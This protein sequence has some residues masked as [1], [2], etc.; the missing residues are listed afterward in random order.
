[1]KAIPRSICIWTLVG[2]VIPLIWLCESCRYLAFQYEQPW[3]MPLEFL[4]ILPVS[5]SVS[6]SDRA[7]WN[8][9]LAIAI[10]SLINA[11]FYA[12]LGSAI[13]GLRRLENKVKSRRANSV[14]T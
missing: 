1:M 8:P 6:V 13:W 7:Y 9:E 12:L 14:G 5:L 4:V 2:A 11:C 10:G 3:L